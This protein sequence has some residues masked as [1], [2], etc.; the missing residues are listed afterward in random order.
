MCK[1]LLHTDGSLHTL[2]TPSCV[3]SSPDYCFSHYVNDQVC[4]CNFH[5]LLDG[6]YKIKGFSHYFSDC[7]YLVPADLTVGQFVYV[8]RKRI[9]LSAD[10]AI[11]VFVKNILPP[12]GELQIF[13]SHL[14]LK[15]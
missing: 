13:F 6:M 2:C 10:K 15:I 8:V 5:T 7:R 9:K 12:T 14:K 3:R 11:F 1:Y 4:L